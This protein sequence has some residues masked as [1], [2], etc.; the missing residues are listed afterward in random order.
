MWKHYDLIDYVEQMTEDAVG[1]LWIAKGSYFGVLEGT[2]WTGFSW[3]EFTVRRAPVIDSR[4]DLWIPSDD[5][6]Y[7]WHQSDLPTAIESSAVPTEPR[8]FHLAQNY[9]NPFNHSTH[10]GFTLKQSAA[11]SLQVFNTHGQLVTTL[12]E[13]TRPAGTYQTA[14]DGHDAQGQAV[15]SGA[16]IVRLDA[17]GQQA[18]RKMILIQ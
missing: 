5:G 17:A 3:E 8:S 1:R 13:G 11:V 6:L 7:R 2:T 18:T 12:V 10:I 9:P 4:G 14:W 16:Y 15:S